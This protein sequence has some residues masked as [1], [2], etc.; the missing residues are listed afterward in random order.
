MHPSTED[1]TLRPPLSLKRNFLDTQARNWLAWQGK[2]LYM[3]QPP[4]VSWIQSKDNMNSLLIVAASE[5]ASN[6]WALGSWTQMCLW[7]E[8]ILPGSVMGSPLCTSHLSTLSNAGY[9]GD[10]LNEATSIAPQ[11]NISPD[12]GEMVTF[13]DCKS[14][15]ALLCIKH[16][17]AGRWNN[18]EMKPL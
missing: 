10:A 16:P 5:Q 15:T 7:R 17:T 1:L 12:V 11:I 9:Q 3:Q 4:T 18:K 8:C 2:V 6:V 13:T 14:L